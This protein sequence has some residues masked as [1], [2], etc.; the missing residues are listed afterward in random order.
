MKARTILLGAALLTSAV[1]AGEEK[2]TLANPDILFILIDSLKASHVGCYG[3]A[4]DTTPN[5]DRFVREERCV[6][7]E[8][9]IPGGSWTM[10][11]VMTLFTALP[12]DGHRRV[13]PSL[14]PRTP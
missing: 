1:T 12:V 11:A 7:F 3:Y 9:V 4:R 14:S 8:T 10:P 2:P 13:L 6:R 5:I